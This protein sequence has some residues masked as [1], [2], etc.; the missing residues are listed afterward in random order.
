MTSPA[1]K[2]PSYSEAIVNAD[3]ISPTLQWVPPPPETSGRSF[4]R[5]HRVVAIPQI[6]P[7]SFRSGPMPFYRA[8]APCLERHSIS[9]HDFI[10]FIDNLVVAQAPNPAIQAVQVAGTGVGFVPHHWAQLAS[11]GIGVGATVAGAATSET[12]TRMY[13][14]K[15]NTDF[16]APR[17]LKVSLV[18][19]DHLRNVAG[20]DPY[21]T[22][23]VEMNPALGVVTVAERR[24]QALTGYIAPLTFN[25]PCPRQQSNKLDRL[26]ARQVQS[27]IKKNREQAVKKAAKSDSKKDIKS[28]GKLKWILVENLRS[29]EVSFALT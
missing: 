12:R 4:P 16:F 13:M 3:N 25:V 22:G 8:Y 6:E 14:S 7:N 10:S 17:G 24:L 28:A 26:S 18:K 9:M 1:T 2:P 27:K 21:R 15:V 19:D 5:L 23:I 20:E 11:L 29:G